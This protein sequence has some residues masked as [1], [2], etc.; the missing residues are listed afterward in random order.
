MK[1]NALAAVAAL[2]VVSLV[3][4]SMSLAFTD[5]MMDKIEAPTV[6]E[7]GVLLASYKGEGRDAQQAGE[8][9]LLKHRVPR[10]VTYPD[11]HVPVLISK[12]DL[13]AVQKLLGEAGV[14]TLS[15]SLGAK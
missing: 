2:A 11:S 5:T 8:I 14:L 4:C 9:L 15:P 3:I 10:V 12:R 7:P 1:K 13:A 6:A